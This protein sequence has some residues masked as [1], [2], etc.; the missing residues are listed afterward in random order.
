M[1]PD[2][3]ALCAELLA[4]DP[5]DRP[6]AAA[7]VARM[8]S[9]ALPED[10]GP[11][12]FVGRS[13]ELGALA[14]A[15]DDVEAGAALAVFIEGES[16]IGKS[17]L[18]KSFVEQVEAGRGRALVLA[19]RCYE[20]ESVPFKGIDGVVDALTRELVRRHPIDVALL[21]S[22]EVEA[23]ARLF[24]VLR[25]VPAIARLSVPRPASPV[26]LRARAFR[27]LRHLLSA[28]AEA[29]PLVVIIDDVQWADTDSIAV[30]REILHPPGAP[31]LLAVLTRRSDAGP[32]P[33]LPGPIRTIALGRLTADEGRALIALLA[34]ARAAEAD[35]L[36]DDAGGHPMFLQELVRHTSAPRSA[37]RLDDALWARVTRMEPNARRVLELVAVAG[38]PLPQGV[39]QQAL[40][41]EPATFTKALG[42]LRATSLVRTGGTRGSDPVEPYH[43]R[44][45]EAVVAHVPPPRRRRYH[46]R[47]AAILI[48]SQVADKDPL[49]VVHHLEAAGAVDLA[50]DLAAQAA[51]RADEALAFEL[52]A[53]LWAA[54]LRLGDHDDD[55]RRDLLV[56]RAEN[57]A[58]AGRGPESAEAFLAAADGADPQAGFQCRR[59]AAH[60]LLVSGHVH[61]G[62][63]LPRRGARR[64]RHAPAALERGGQALAGVGVD[65][66]RGARHRLSRAD[67]AR[68]PD[69]RPPAARRHADRVARARH[70]RRPARR[71]VPGPGP[72]DRAPPRRPAPHRLRARLS[73]DVPGGQRHPGAGGAQ[74]GRRG[75]RI[76]EGVRQRVPAGLGPH[77]RGHHRV[78][79]RALARRR[80]SC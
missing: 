71:R 8:S 45:R 74:P 77:R 52:A 40:A 54:A 15:L 29:S 79:R 11:T 31:R 51:R 75:R 12:P 27:G 64:D 66:D 32:P 67:H 17:S 38:A 24:P 30:L 18:V 42:I 23:L 35:A 10:D 58:Y 2:L 55:L 60:E 6:T 65:P 63:R 1:P 76:A 9:R 33:D 44:V 21:L 62:L 49:T 47:L 39:V 25:R 28:L 5:E 50:A 59:M 16:G 61:E 68:R 4:T 13:A 14:A 46:E 26:E 37:S 73:R 36:I 53:E 3:A 48:A 19:G 78:L 72:P 20:R 80:S 57:L 70:G 43:D 41:L 69:P 22:P 34:P 7:V 56:R